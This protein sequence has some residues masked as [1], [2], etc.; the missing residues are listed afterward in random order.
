MNGV[1]DVCDTSRDRDNDGVQDGWD[2]CELVPNSD[3]L[4]TD[5]DAYG[6][7]LQLR[8]SAFAMYV[9]NILSC[10]AGDACDDDDDND[11]VQDARDN[12]PKVKNNAQSDSNGMCMHTLHA[13]GSP[14]CLVLCNQ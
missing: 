11:G 4:N 5:G 8:M 3:Q 14:R 1:G 6:Q 9:L 7:S 13:T 10:I 12:C 2:N